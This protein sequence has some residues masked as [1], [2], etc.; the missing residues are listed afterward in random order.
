MVIGDILTVEFFDTKERALG[1]GWVY[2]FASFIP[3][4]GNM[5]ITPLSLLFSWGFAF[6]LIS[7]FGIAIVLI[8]PFFLPE[9]K[10]R[11]L[12][13]IYITEIEKGQF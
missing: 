4:F 7:T 1:A 10:S 12:E 13:E 2:W 5:L 3:I 11:V 8:V 6:F 9:T